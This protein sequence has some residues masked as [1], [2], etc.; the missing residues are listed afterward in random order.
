MTGDGSAVANVSKH[1]TF[2][3]GPRVVA[4]NETDEA[5]VA[6]AGPRSVRAVHRF[7]FD[8]ER[9]VLGQQPWFY[10]VLAEFETKIGRLGESRSIVIRNLSLPHD[11]LI[12]LPV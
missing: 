12:A 11:W 6:V 2:L 5:V 9:V 4:T 3:H 7:A 1:H 10:I 8:E